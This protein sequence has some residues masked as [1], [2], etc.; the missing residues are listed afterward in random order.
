MRFVTIDVLINKRT[1]GVCL[2]EFKCWEQAEMI[3][4]S[5]ERGIYLHIIN[6]YPYYM[7][8]CFCI[9]YLI[10]LFFIEMILK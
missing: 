9:F 3:F 4:K 5:H 1:I 6:A 10:Y 7:N 2:K 8:P